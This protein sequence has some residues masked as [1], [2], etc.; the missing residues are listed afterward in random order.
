MV[1]Y[2]C[3]ICLKGVDFVF[4]EGDLKVKTQFTAY[5]SKTFKIV[6]LF[7]V[8][9]QH[10]WCLVSMLATIRH[11]NSHTSLPEIMRMLM[12]RHCIP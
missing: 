1:V 11:H 6:T 4:Q 8:R 3:I 7:Y 12:R 9:I 5:S 2:Y 10:A